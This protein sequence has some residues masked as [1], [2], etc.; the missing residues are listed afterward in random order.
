[1]FMWKEQMK[2]NRSEMDRKVKRIGG[3]WTRFLLNIKRSRCKHSVQV[4][5]LSHQSVSKQRQVAAEHRLRK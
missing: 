5:L 4:I 1:M 3:H 2:K